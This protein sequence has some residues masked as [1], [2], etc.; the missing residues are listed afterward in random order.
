M[1]AYVMN[2]MEVTDP[3]MLRKREDMTHEQ[4]DPINSVETKTLWP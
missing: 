1:P 4:F 2:D 3:A